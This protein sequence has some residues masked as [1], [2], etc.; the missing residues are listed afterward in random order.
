MGAETQSSA[1]KSYRGHGFARSTARLGARALPRQLSV[2]PLG[3]RSALGRLRLRERG[4]VLAPR[5]R[6]RAAAR[7]RRRRLPRVRQA[8]LLRDHLRSAFMRARSI[9]DC[10]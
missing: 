8:R 7:C 1:E 3:L 4:R 9:N 5:G 2:Q 6:L 10:R